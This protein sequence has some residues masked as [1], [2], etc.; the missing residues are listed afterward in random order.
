MSSRRSSAITKL[1]RRARRDAA[2][3][4]SAWRAGQVP[5]SKRKKSARKLEPHEVVA[6]L[7]ARKATPKHRSPA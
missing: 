4:A 1:I 3:S 5:C 6:M 2:L 7:K